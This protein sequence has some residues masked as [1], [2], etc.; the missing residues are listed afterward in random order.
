MCFWI[1]FASILLSI[2]T[3][4][5]MSEIGL[6]FSFLEMSLH[7]LSIRVILASSKKAFVNVP[8]VSIMWNTLRSIDIS[9]S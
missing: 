2:F 6:E 3:L 1:R 8:S 9:S 7:G 5:F 4:M